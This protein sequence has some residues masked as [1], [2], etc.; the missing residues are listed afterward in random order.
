MKNVVKTFF[1]TIDE[2]VSASK[3]AFFKLLYEK[4][5]LAFFFNSF[6]KKIAKMAVF[7]IIS[8]KNGVLAFFS[9]SL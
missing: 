7:H 8:W 6:M 1:N 2:D 9:F 4:N 3:M 5:H